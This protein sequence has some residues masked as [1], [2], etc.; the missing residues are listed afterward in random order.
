MASLLDSELIWAGISGE[1]EPQALEN[2]GGG[3][4]VGYPDGSDLP[5]YWP[6]LCVQQ[7]DTGGSRGWRVGDSHSPVPG[8]K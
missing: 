6:G 3:L 1:G 8:R 4:S 5:L 7:G 2:W